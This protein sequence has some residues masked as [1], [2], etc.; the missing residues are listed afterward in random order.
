MMITIFWFRVRSEITCFII[1]LIFFCS[2]CD[3]RN[4]SYLEG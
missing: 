2:K 3:R 1:A 4:F